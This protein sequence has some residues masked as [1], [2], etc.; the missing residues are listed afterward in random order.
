MTLR[1]SPVAT[2][3]ATPSHCPNSKVLAHHQRPNRSRGRRADLA[4]KGPLGLEDEVADDVLEAQVLR[5]GDPFSACEPT[6]CGSARAPE[7]TADR[8]LNALSAAS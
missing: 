4:R 3:L 1:V 2:P 7:R 5:V 8:R 6:A